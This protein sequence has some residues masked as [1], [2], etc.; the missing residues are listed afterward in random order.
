MFFASPK[1][2]S[3]GVGLAV[4]LIAAATAVAV[5]YLTSENTG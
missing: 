4:M 1:R 3:W 2:L 5:V